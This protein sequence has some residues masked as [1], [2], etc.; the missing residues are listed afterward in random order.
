MNIIATFATST[1]TLYKQP[2]LCLNC[3]SDAGRYYPKAELEN[4]LNQRKINPLVGF[5]DSVNREDGSL[6]LDDIQGIAKNFVIEENTLFADIE[7]LIHGKLHELVL[8]DKESVVYS[9][10]IRYNRATVD[11]DMGISLA[12]IH[13]VE[14]IGILANPHQTRFGPNWTL[15]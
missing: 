6:N 2:L 14:I 1:I 8:K 10:F 4:T 15:Q 12:V 9:P 13:D 3:F 5:I 11:E 7:I